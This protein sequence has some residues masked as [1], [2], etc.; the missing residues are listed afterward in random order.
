MKNIQNIYIS[1]AI[2]GL[3]VLLMSSFYSGV[4]VQAGRDPGNIGLFNI[5]EDIYV[6]TEEVQNATL[7]VTASEANNIDRAANFIGGT[8]QVMKLPFQSTRLF[9]NLITIM[10]EQVGIPH[11]GLI[12]ALIMLIIGIILSFDFLK[13]VR[14]I[15]G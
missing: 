8:F 3:I 13:Y 5:T 9:G 1:G 15:S 7:D 12:V 14:G 11:L 2:I 4:V 10:G 6:Q